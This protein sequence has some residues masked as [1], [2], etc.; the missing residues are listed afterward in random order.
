MKQQESIRRIL[1]EE[2]SIKDKLKNL[3]GKSGILNTIRAVGG[4]SNFKKVYGNDLTKDEKLKLITDIVEKYGDEVVGNIEV[5]D[6]DIFVYKERN[7]T[8]HPKYTTEVIEIYD[9]GYYA[10]NQYGYDEILDEYDWESPRSGIAR[11]INLSDLE[12]DN[13]IWVLSKIKKI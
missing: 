7:R 11:L 4:Y 13:I 9:N 2:I 1:R 3:I 6:H 10:F 8:G 5:R 12:L